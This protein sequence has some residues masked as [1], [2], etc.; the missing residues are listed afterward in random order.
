MTSR[1][2]LQLRI[3]ERLHAHEL[4]GVA[5]RRE[6]I[7]QLVRQHGKKLVL[8]AI[9]LL[10][11][12]LGPGTLRHFALQRVIGALEL[13][14]GPLQRRVERLQLAGLLRLQRGVRL[15]ELLV[16][17]RQVRLSSCSSRRLQYSST[18]TATLLRRISGTTGIDT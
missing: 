10:E 6:R 9:G 5:D 8:V 1:D 2:Q 17:L 4:H 12:L 7:A 15:R 16:G 14:V 18:S 3:R 11:R 13:R